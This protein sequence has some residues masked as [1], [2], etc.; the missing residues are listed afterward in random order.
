[1]GKMGSKVGRS[2]KKRGNGERYHGGSRMEGGVKIAPL[3]ETE[4]NN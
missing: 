4:K 1:M 3:K 2:S